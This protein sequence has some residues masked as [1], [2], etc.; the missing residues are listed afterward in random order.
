MT[1][2]VYQVFYGEHYLYGEDRFN[3]TTDELVDHLKE[4]LKYQDVPH[5][6]NAANVYMVDGRKGKREFQCSLQRAKNGRVVRS[7][8]IEIVEQH[9]PIVQ[10]ETY[11]VPDRNIGWLSTATEKL[12]RKAKKL[13]L[14]AVGFEI[15]DTEVLKREDG[16]V[17]IFHTI[18]PL[19]DAPILDGWKLAATLQHEEAGNVVRAVP[20][21]VLPAS[22]RSTKSVCEHCGTWRYRKETFVVR[23]EDGRLLQVGRSCLQDFLGGKSPHS[24][25]SWA[26]YVMDIDALIQEARDREGGG[27]YIRP[28]SL[29]A[30]LEYAAQHTIA[31]GRFIGAAAAR[32]Y[33]MDSTASKALSD[34]F[35]PPGYHHIPIVLTSEGEELAASALAWVRELEPTSDY[36]HN[37]KVITSKEYVQYKDTNIAASLIGAF[38][39]ATEQRKRREQRAAVGANSQHIGTIGKRDIYTAKLEALIGFETDYG[40][41]RIHKFLDAAGNLL[42]WKTTSNPGIEEGEEVTFK[43]TLKDHDLYD[44]VKQNVLS[45]LAVQ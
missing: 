14:G 10:P 33:E 40:Y 8:N 45:R 17:D 36:E 27:S 25:I 20:G 6:L 11:R 1:K 28:I 19:G 35:P 41:M 9:P 29:L 3:G 23:H 39:R 18:K 13:G 15:V 24:L 26:S 4:Q 44:G 16:T 37:L 42:V 21:E 32:E 38:K 5:D 43:A 2:L 30:L 22:F 31:D 7:N 12:M 34:M